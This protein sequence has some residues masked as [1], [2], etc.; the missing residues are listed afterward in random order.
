MWVLLDDLFGKGVIG[1]RFEPSLSLLDAL[2]ASFR[3]ASAFLL[4]AAGAVVRNGWLCV[5]LV[6]L[7]E[8]SPCLSKEQSPKD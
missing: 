8:K 1:V 7:D 4:Q 2:Q 5:G 3:A 6:S